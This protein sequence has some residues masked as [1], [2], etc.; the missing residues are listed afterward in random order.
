MGKIDSLSQIEG[1][2][3]PD[4]AREYNDLAVEPIVE[5]LHD[6]TLQHMADREAC[7]QQGCER[8]ERGDP[9]EAPE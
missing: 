8:R 5:P 2:V 4:G 1:A 6:E 3:R 9:Q 7:E